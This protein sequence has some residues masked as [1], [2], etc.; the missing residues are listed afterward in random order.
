MKNFQIFILIFIFCISCRLNTPDIENNGNP[1]PGNQSP[2]EFLKLVYNALD[3]T[4]FTNQGRNAGEYQTLY[5]NI[6][7]AYPGAQGLTRTDI[8]NKY[9][10]QETLLAFTSKEA[11]SGD[12]SQSLWKDKTKGGCFYKNNFPNNG[13]RI[14]NNKPDPKA[15]NVYR[16]M[17]YNVHNFHRTCPEDNQNTFPTGYERKS[18]AH[19]SQ[20]FKDVDADLIL[21][22]EIVPMPVDP[23]NKPT[24]Q[25]NFTVNVS[26]DS[27][28][29]YFETNNN[30]LEWVAV[31]DHELFKPPHALA[32]TGL[33]KAIFSQKK[34]TLLNP[35]ALFL[36]DARSRSV[37]RSLVKIKNKY[38][39]VYNVHLTH[40]NKAQHTQ[41]IKNLVFI[42]EKDRE[43]FKKDHN[44]AKIPALVMGDFNT[45]YFKNTNNY[46]ELK[47]KKYKSLNDKEFTG[48]NQGDR[49][50]LAF[51]SEDFESFFEIVSKDNNGKKGVRVLPR[52][53]S[54]HY[55]ILLEIKEK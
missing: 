30:L 17:S 41:E 25:N 24:L 2:E 23:N 5:G 3:K 26:L 46:Q 45:D 48:F 11:F 37:L 20:V 18:L 6:Q 47:N 27:V 32:K 28:G 42:M 39:L 7:S 36:G 44:F 33:G 49:L 9:E 51:V 52:L 14:K 22:Q 21:L 54:D 15:K 12:N 43:L 16:I 31:N 55:P 19:A 8:P 53:E 1:E 29:K 34:E 4:A 50:D 35:N 10:K 40:N 13:E 38:L